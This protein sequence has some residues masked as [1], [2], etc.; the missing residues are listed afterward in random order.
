M[1]NEYAATYHLPGHAKV[2]MLGEDT[3]LRGNTYIA[4]MDMN[5]DKVAALLDTFLKVNSLDS[6]VNTKPP[7]KWKWN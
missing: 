4:F 2:L 6:F 5:N 3:P 7:G 1:L